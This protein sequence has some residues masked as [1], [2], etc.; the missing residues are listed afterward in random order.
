MYKVCENIVFL[1][2]NLIDPLMKYTNERLSMCCPLL[3]HSRLAFNRFESDCKCRKHLIPLLNDLEY[4]RLLSV[5]PTEQLAVVV[6]VSQ[7]KITNIE[8]IMTEM[9]G[10]NN[11]TRLQPCKESVKDEVRFFRYDVNCA[12]VNSNHS[13]PL[14]ITR[15]NVSP[16]MVLVSALEA[17]VRARHWFS[18]FLVFGVWF[19]L[20]TW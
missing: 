4:D 3:M 2:S 18:V 12:T 16:G 5:I 10:S 7:G 14:L 6:V 17:W 19:V 15:H 13:S 1:C 11:R 9:Y 20:S 8:A